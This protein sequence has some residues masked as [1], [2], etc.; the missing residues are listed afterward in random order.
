[1]KYHNLTPQRNIQSLNPLPKIKWGFNTGLARFMKGEI[2]RGIHLKNR[3]KLARGRPFD[4]MNVR[5]D[6]FLERYYSHA[7]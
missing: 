6:D 5:K 3:W 4:C 1:M 7:I 2:E